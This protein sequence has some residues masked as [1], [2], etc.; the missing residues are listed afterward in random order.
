VS[1]AEDKCTCDPPSQALD[2][3][4]RIFRIAPQ[5]KLRVPTD[6]V[7]LASPT[8]VQ[9]LTTHI[10]DLYYRPLWNHGSEE[11]STLGRPYE[12]LYLCQS[13]DNDFRISELSGPATAMM[14]STI[15]GTLSSAAM[16]VG[17]TL[18]V[19]STE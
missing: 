7:M 16:I 17:K 19:E 18:G 4:D 13:S 6:Y 8:F 10:S 12:S 1:I 5:T 2:G 11:Q 9:F 3:D 14:A 15:C